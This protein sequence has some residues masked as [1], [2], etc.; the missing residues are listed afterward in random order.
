MKILSGIC[1]RKF[2]N[3]FFQSGNTLSYFNQVDKKHH[4]PNKTTVMNSSQR[5]ITIPQSSGFSLIEV[6][7]SLVLV[8]IFA[9]MIVPFFQTGVYQSAE[10]VQMREELYDLNTVMA[11]MVAKYEAEYK[12]KLGDLYEAIGSTGTTQDNEDFG[13]YFVVSSTL[14]D[15]G[16]GTDNGLLITISGPNRLGN[17]T[18]LFTEKD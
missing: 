17:L 7:I 13:Q 3:Q 6:I 15:I 16:S 18:Y 14:K 5:P 11:N 12:T 10:L 8:G 2:Q 4:D 1:S 9:A